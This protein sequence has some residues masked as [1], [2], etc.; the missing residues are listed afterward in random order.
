VSVSKRLVITIAVILLAACQTT[1]YRAGATTDFAQDKYQ[2]LQE[3]QQQSS[4]TYINKYYGAAESGS[5]T[6]T[7]LL[8]SCLEARGW[9]RNKP[10]QTS[11]SPQIKKP[12][13]TAQI[14]FNRIYTQAE[15]TEEAFKKCIAPIKS[16]PSY[17]RLEKRFVMDPDDDPRLLE[18]MSI[19]EYATEQEIKD[20][21]ELSAMGKPC[22]NQAL[23]GYRQVHP[24]L[25]TMTANLLK[26]DYLDRAKLINKELT[27]GEANQRTLARST[28]AKAEASRLG[29]RI[30]EQL[31]NQSHQE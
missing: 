26:E 8:N 3:S 12:D 14:E 16:S 9:S 25:G 28:Q 15:S 17:R 4:N 21:R 23:G 24:E 20:I 6:N 29:Q 11:N 31:L 19:T 1:W 22:E 13:T 5:V 27:V 10:Q 30:R 18:K 7:Y 2:C